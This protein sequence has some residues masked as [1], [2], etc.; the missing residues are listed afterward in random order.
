MWGEKSELHVEEKKSKTMTPPPPPS[1]L[2][3]VL[4]EATHSSRVVVTASVVGIV[5]VSQRQN[6]AS[7]RYSAAPFLSVEQ[8][9]HIW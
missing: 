3:W 6:P 4:L 8:E 7:A 5:F 2:L 9:G 1:S